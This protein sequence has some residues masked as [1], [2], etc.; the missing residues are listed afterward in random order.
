M[1]FPDHAA[2]MI[3]D[4]LDSGRLPRDVNPKMYA[5]YGDGQQCDGCEMPISAAQVEWEF[6]ARRRGRPSAFISGARRSGKPT[7][8]GEAGTRR[9]PQLE[10]ETRAA[11]AARLS[12]CPIGP[13]QRSNT[14]SVEQSRH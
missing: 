2:Q 4:K 13:R 10:R 6:V 11:G 8:V 1:P 12:V 5:G 9:P 14:N 7:G 3:H